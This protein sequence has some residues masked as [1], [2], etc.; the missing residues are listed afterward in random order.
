MA[1]NYSATISKVPPFCDPIANQTKRAAFPHRRSRRRCTL[2]RNQNHFAAETHCSLEFPGSFFPLPRRRQGA[3]GRPVDSALALQRHQITLIEGRKKEEVGS[4][5]SEA[6]MRR[7]SSCSSCAVLLLS[8]IFGREATA[9]HAGRRTKD[10]I[11]RLAKAQITAGPER[12][13]DGVCPTD[14]SACPATLNG[15]CCPSAYACATD[16]CYATTAG[17]STAC[18]KAG[19]FACAISAGG[20]WL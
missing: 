17:T 9:S 15:G 4:A 13:D 12:R 11:H 20:E 7:V 8:A 5:H 1:P 14:Y 18:G 10:L 2:P 16:S 6:A 3:T 19:F